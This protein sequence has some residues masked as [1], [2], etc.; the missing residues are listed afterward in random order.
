MHSGGWG[1]TVVTSDAF[2]HTHAS[3]VF[4]LGIPNSFMMISYQHKFQDEDHT[5]VKGSLK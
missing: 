2:P 4:Q 5:R 1:C 3:L